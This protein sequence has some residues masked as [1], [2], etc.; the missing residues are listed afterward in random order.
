M[1]GTHTVRRPLAQRLR[2][3]R[4]RPRPGWWRTGPACM[5]CGHRRVHEAGAHDEHAG[6][7]AGERV[8]EALGEAVEAGLRRRRRRSC[9]LRTRSPATLDSTT[10]RPWPWRRNWAATASAD[11]DRAGEVDGDE[12]RPRRAGSSSSSAWSTELP[13]GDDHDV[14]VAVA[15][16]RGRATKRVVGGACRWRRSARRRR[17]ARGRSSSAGA[18]LGSGRRPASTTVRVAGDSRRSTIARPMS[19]V[20]PSSTM[21]CGSPSA[22]S[23]RSSGQISRRAGA[24]GGPGR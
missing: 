5:P 4:R 7:G 20:P 6:A 14:E 9:A 19:L 10:R 21:V 2:R 17:S 11:A 8:A 12:R 24:A 22:L 23:M 16:R 1:P 15:R 3:S 18:R 13:E